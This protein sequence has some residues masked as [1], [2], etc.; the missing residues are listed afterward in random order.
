MAQFLKSLVDVALGDDVFAYLASLVVGVIFLGTPH[1]GSAAATLG[2]FIA[3]TGK[4]LGQ[5]SE[6]S[7][8]KDLQ[9]DSESLNDLRDK[10]TLWA[11]RTSLTLRC[12]FEQYETYYGKIPGFSLGQMVRPTY[13]QNDKAVAHLYV[14]IRL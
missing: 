2:T 6:D 10:F 12:F 7:I 8:V 3:K 11:N 13:A 4:F 9:V 1:R 14:L 5:R